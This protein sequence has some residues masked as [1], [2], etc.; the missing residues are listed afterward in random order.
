MPLTKSN[1]DKS[2]LIVDAKYDFVNLIKR[3]L[4]IEGRKTTAFT[5]PFMALEYFKINCKDCSLIMS[6][7]RM[8]GMNGYELIR[9]AKE[10]KNK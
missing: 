9:K 2:V 3:S 7:I 1:N 5:D 4:E 6:D 10:I 8:P